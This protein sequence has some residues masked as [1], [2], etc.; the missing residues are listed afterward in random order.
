MSTAGTKSPSRG[1][2]DPMSLTF[3]RCVGLY[4]TGVAVVACEGAGEPAGMTINSFIS[5]SLDPLMILVSL[6]SQ[7]R[8]LEAVRRDPR[9]SVSLLQHSQLDAAVRFS[10]PQAPFP[11]DLVE[12]RGD[13][14]VVPEAL[15]AL[16]CEAE[17]LLEV[18]DH[19]LVLARVADFESREGEP[20]LFYRGDFGTLTAISDEEFDDLATAMAN[21]RRE[22]V[23]M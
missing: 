9:F 11:L 18:G 21:L 19:H 16:R 6:H 7:S 5:V 22:S 20:L 2:R 14:L 13:F 8:T 17:Q 23:A 3:R 10:E 4:P 15:A 12:R 1:R